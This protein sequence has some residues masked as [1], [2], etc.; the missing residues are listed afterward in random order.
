MTWGYICACMCPM[1]STG[2]R[3]DGSK[4]DGTGVMGI[5]SFQRT[6]Q[7]TKKRPCVVLSFIVHSLQQFHFYALLYKIQSALRFACDY[8]FLEVSPRG[9][10][11]DN[12]IRKG[13][14]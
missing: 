10:Y 14:V 8:C 3:W 4:R 2:R 9:Y 7:K 6:K 12:R 11:R 13:A 5:K 1:E